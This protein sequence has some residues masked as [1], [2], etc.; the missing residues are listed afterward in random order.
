MEGQEADMAM[1]G[2]SSAQ[3]VALTGAAARPPGTVRAIQVLLRVLALL[4]FAQPVF[5]G[6]LLDGY[7]TW[8]DWHGT[9]G[10]AVI[11]LLTLTLI[12]LM[13]VA[14]RA[15]HAPGWMPLVGVG[16]A[17]AIVVQNIAGNTSALWLHVPL[18][19]AILGGVG[20]LIARVRTLPAAQAGRR[21]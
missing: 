6:L 10:M 4:V 13:T 14:W 12:V 19:V 7:G 3:G 5:A 16:M 18:G 9:T 15:G 8:R 21:G 1:E 17:L 2:S 20:S 11:P